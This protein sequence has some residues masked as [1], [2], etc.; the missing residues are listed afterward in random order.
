MNAWLEFLVGLGVG[1]VFL[2][3]VLA[4]WVLFGAVLCLGFWLFGT[5]SKT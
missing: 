3:G 4:G 2:A 1:G 5:K